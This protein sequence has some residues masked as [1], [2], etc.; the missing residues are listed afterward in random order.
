MQFNQSVQLQACTPMSGAYIVKFYKMA[1]CHEMG[2]FPD[3]AQNYS[4]F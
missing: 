3:A 1:E 4:S 2:D